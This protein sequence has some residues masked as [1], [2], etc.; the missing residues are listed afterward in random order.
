VRGFRVDARILEADDV[1]EHRR[2][3]GVDHRRRGGCERERGNDHLVA[4][5]DAGGQVGEVK[6]GCAARHGHGVARP[7][8]LGEGLLESRGAR[9][10]R[11][12][13]TAQRLGDRVQILRFEA[14]VEE[15]DLHLP[16]SRA[17]H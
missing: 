11:E 10:H 5:T 14:K 4:G 6:R 1:R 16:G 13:A 2:A 12:P 15:R 7:E 8:M 9:P 3:S 17:R